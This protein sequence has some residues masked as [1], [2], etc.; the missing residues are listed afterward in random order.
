MEE[1]RS[2][3]VYGS[4]GTKQIFALKDEAQRLLE[5]VRKKSLYSD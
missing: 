1:R 5:K 2:M 4:P 3:K